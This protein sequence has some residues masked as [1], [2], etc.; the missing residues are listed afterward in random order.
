MTVVSRV[1]LVS[2]NIVVAGAVVVICVNLLVL[3]EAVE[4]A[5][6]V[7]DLIFKFS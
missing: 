5:K 6:S 1:A 2:N 7:T 3:V 4:F